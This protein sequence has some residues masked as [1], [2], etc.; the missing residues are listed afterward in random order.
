MLDDGN[1]ENEAPVR[2]TLSQKVTFV[3]IM[4]D[5]FCIQR[6]TPSEVLCYPV[7]TQTKMIPK[8]QVASAKTDACTSSSENQSSQTSHCTSEMSNNVSECKMTLVIEK[9]AS[10]GILYFCI[11]LCSN[12]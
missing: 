8:D 4:L 7:E 9:F 12:V 11:F 10:I 6:D 5:N 2:F 1:P 3:F